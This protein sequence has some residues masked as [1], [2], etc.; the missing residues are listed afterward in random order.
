[1]ICLF[2]VLEH[3]QNDKDIL[4]TIYQITNINGFLVLTVPAYPSLWSSHDVAANHVRRYTFPGLQDRVNSAGFR[5]E[6]TTHFFTCLW[7]FM[8]L[9]R[10][11][12]SWANS[13]ISNIKIFQP[14]FRSD[15]L[16][17]LPVLNEIILKIL[18][19]ERYLIA[20]RR[21]L[22]FGTSLLVVARRV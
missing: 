18:A 6:Y 2:D 7:P 5:I 19:I 17:V 4:K 10:M 22:F 11:I 13:K 9:R 20:R 8:K 1:V 15:G 16:A 3:I 21:K 14:S 12:D